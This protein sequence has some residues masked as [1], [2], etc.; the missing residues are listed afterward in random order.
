MLEK[1]LKKENIILG[2]PP[3]NKWQILE[4][5]T[6]IY[7]KNVPDKVKDEIFLSVLSREIKLSTGLSGS[8]AI[9]HGRCKLVNE[10]GLLFCKFDTP[11]DWES[12]D[13]Q[14]TNF[15][16][17]VISP[18]EATDE[19]LKLLS[20]ISKMISRKVLKK[21]L[22]SA[23]TKEQVYKLIINA[24]IRKTKRKKII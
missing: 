17:L 5:L 7:C 24:K 18:E 13:N 21:A 10:I 19:Y 3:K 2:L 12:I 1:Y 9:P 11:I 4:I 15:V 20:D 22:L 8:V 14:K 23:K 6:R 16:F